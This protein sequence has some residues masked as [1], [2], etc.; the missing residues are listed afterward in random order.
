M[1]LFRYGSD[2][3]QAGQGFH[4]GNADEIFRQMFG[5]G[6]GGPGRG[7]GVHF[8]FG[9][10]GLGGLFQQMNRGRHGGRGD[11]EAGGGGGV[12]LI[13][14]LPLVFMFLPV[15]LPMLGSILSS[16]SVMLIPMALMLPP[17]L[18]KPAFFLFLFM[19]IFG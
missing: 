9:P 7:G 11:A 8:Q 4:A 14:M 10:G 18:R 13:R 3:D 17:H 12:N 2:S 1:L 16:R 6:F 19:T 15:V 5:G